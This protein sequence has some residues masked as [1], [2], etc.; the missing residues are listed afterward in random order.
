MV[1]INK[2]G[3]W[4]KPARIPFAINTRGSETSF[5]LS[6]SGKEIYYVTDNG[7]GSL[8]GKDI[9][10][11]R[12]ISDRKWSKPQNAGSLI[13]TIYDEEAVRFS[14]TGDTLWFSSKGHSS[15]GGFDI[16]YSVKNKSGD[17]DTVK[18]AGYPV[19]T[20]WDE[21]FYYPSPVNDSTFYFVSNRTGGFGGLDIYKGR[22][23]PP[24]RI[25]IPPAP[26]P[27]TVTIRDTVL[28]VKEVVPSPAIVQEPAKET[29]LYLV[30]KVKDSETGEPVLAKLDV[31]DIA[32]NAVITTTASSDVDGSYR[33]RLPA[34][35]SYL[36]D[37][38]ATGFLS[39]TRRIDVPDNW[40]KDVYNLNIE[41]IKVKIGKK[42]VLNNILFETGKSILT[43]TSNVELDRLLNIMK[44][45]AQIKIEIS[46]H[47]DKTG[48]EPL[49]FKLSEARA[50]AVVEY[51]AQKGIDRSRM[52]FRG[53]G[54]LQPISDNTTP[55]GRAKNRR[56]EF[57]ILEF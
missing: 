7:K 51:L 5:T 12:K 4:K 49:N 20:P 42:V 11:I 35:K 25:I 21:I 55:K 44:E 18:N 46:G 14:K 34:K 8:G 26:K 13:N 38:R 52:E 30:G 50:K 6:P 22:I 33:V 39:D 48:S 47:T 19:N 53:Y 1:S 16:F 15:I 57:K 29:V 17:W 3:I 27:D 28:V 45:N 10:Y 41:L 31:L 32:T 40:L 23:L 43:A 24:E 36:I 2:K 56:V 54:S 37:L 9:Y